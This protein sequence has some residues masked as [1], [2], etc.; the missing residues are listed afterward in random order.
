MPALR[1][2]ILLV[3]ILAGAALFL[4]HPKGEPGSE[5]GIWYWHSP[6][7]VTDHERDLL[8][9]AGVSTVYVRAGTFTTDGKRLLLVLPQVWKSKA[10]GLR[11]VSVFNFDPGLLKHFGELPVEVMAGDVSERIVKSLADEKSQGIEPDGVQLDIDCPT[12]LLPKYADFLGRVRKAIGPV[13]TFSITALPTWLTSRDIAQV[14]RQVDFIVPQFYEGRAGRTLQDIKPI[15][16][17]A[18]LVAGIRRLNRLGVPYQVGLPAYGHALLFDDQGRLVSMYRGLSSE[19]AL[20]LSA[21]RHVS[22][23]PLDADGHPAS[24]KSYVGEDLMTVEAVKPD[25]G[26]RGKGDRIVYFLPAPE[27]VS[28][29]LAD[30][31]AEAG[32]FCR[33]VVLYRFPEP[34]ETTALPLESIVAAIRLEPKTVDF[35]IEMRARSVPYALIGERRASSVPRELHLKLTDVGNVATETAPDALEALVEFDRPGIGDVA[36]GDFDAVQP[37]TLEG[38]RFVPCGRAR[39]TALLLRRF[40]VQPGQVLHSGGIELMQDGP[41]AVHVQWTAQ[42]MGGFHAYHGSSP[43]RKLAELTR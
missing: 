42:G 28:R 14:A 18:A 23:V 29:Q 39:A 5:V 17:P 22:T 10:E 35:G 4:R 26:G 37:G 38:G 25:L 33:G 41:T 34:G 30:A 32:S 36:P 31:R 27:M 21:L 16:D 19:D 13:G 20:R 3:A 6:F 12:R 9:S 15:S 40:N 7:V 43:T 2:L 11:I 1:G 8:K 24:E